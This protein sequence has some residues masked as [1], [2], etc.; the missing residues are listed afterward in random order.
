[1]KKILILKGIP[2]SGK[3]TYAKE[4]IKENPGMYKRINRD[5]LREMLDESH[6]SKGNEKFVRKVRDL[7]IMEGLNDGKHIIVDDTNI[8]SSNEEHIR[9]LADRHR[10]ETGK[11]VKVEV[12]LFEIDLEEAIKRDAQRAKSVGA[13]VIRKMHRQ[14]YGKPDTDDRG[15]HYVDQDK[16]LQPAIICD[17]D[18][19]L[20]ILNGR[21]P[22]DASTCENDLLNEPVLEILQTFKA[23]GVEII[24]LSGRTDNF[25]PQTIK[26]LEKY[27]V[28]YDKLIMRKHKDMRKDA[29]IK[30]EIY[31]SA[32]KDKYFIKFVLD[33]RNQVV[34]MWRQ[35]IGLPCMQVNYGDF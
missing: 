8:A 12:K 16:S 33:D 6:F 3:S 4:L 32:I 18:G 9:Q 21:N 15:P 2:A 23:K 26:W 34:D 14:L 5:A 11:E 31:D 17:L 35:D 10:N 19:T 24:L 28:E 25:K 29:I 20:C 30:K 1:M 27:D 7:L 22:F 13:N